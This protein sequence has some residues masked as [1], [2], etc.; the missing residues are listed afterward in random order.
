MLWGDS[1]SNRP[2]LEAHIQLSH[3]CVHFKLCLI[4]TI[5]LTL[6]VVREMCLS[7]WCPIR[8]VDVS[9]WSADDVFCCQHFV[10][11][12]L[13]SHVCEKFRSRTVFFPSNLTYT[14][15]LASVPFTTDL[16]DASLTALTGTDSAREQT[17]TPG[18]AAH[19]LRA[20]DE[21]STSVI[22]CPPAGLIVR[23]CNLSLSSCAKCCFQRLALPAVFLPVP[24]SS[25]HQLQV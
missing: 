18:D 23:L 6:R 25:S 8:R 9:R 1:Y 15:G 24:A 7:L 10:G 2:I 11:T 16:P 5:A 3:Q 19:P 14:L 20:G 4:L 13:A 12:C 17:G 21:D 22:G